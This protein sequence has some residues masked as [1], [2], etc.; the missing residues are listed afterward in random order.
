VLQ[1]SLVG[2]DIGSSAVKAGA[3]RESGAPLAVVREA[4]ADRHPEPGAWEADPEEVWAATVRAI[5]RLAAQDE[6]R[7]DPPGALAVSA[8]GREV[9]PA[10]ATGR[11]LGPCLRTGDARTADP[12]AAALLGGTPEGWIQACGHVPDRMDPTNRLLWWRQ[13]RPASWARARRFL[14]WHDLVT[15]R[16]AGRA[17]TDPALASG[18]LLYDLDGGDWSQERLAALDLDRD[19][20]PEIQPWAAPLGTLGRR[21]AGQLGLPAGCL[22]VVGSFDTSCAAVGAGAVAPGVPLLACGSWES[23]V[24]PATGARS[25]ALA[26]SGL[27]VGPHP[28]LAG[29]GVWARSPNGTAAVDWA[30]QLTGVPL[31]SLDRRL[32][33]SGP[34]P[35]PVLAVPHLSGAITPWAVIQARGALLGL[36]LASHPVDVVKAVLEGIACDLA[37]TMRSLDHA[38]VEVR[39]CRTSGGGTRS[40]WWMQLKADLCGVPMEVVADAEAGALGAALLAGLGAGAF[41]SMEEATRVRLR[42]VRRHEPDPARGARYAERL[43]A[44][45]RLVAALLD[46]DGSRPHPVTTAPGP[47]R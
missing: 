40:R 32:A 30:R 19:L 2:V 26:A 12:D 31:R 8:S 43:D 42:T 36:T 3:Y 28:S 35:S 37:L 14:N 13:R 11:P 27:A 29:S 34:D 21:A 1:V 23:M 10:T 38:G 17:V 25:S 39:T 44:Q 24:A 5:S 18:F 16:L 15:L 22:L 45:R 7:R 46:A 4:V 6:L 47:R 41:S 9:F 20:L 33:A